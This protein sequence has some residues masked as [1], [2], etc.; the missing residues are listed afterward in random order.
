[1]LKHE[2]EFSY[3]PRYSCLTLSPANVWKNDLDKFLGDRMIIKTI[4]D[5]KDTSSLESGSLKELLFGLPW[6]QTGIRKL[7]VRN[8]Q[9]A[10]NYAITLVFK[11]FNEELIESLKRTLKQQFPGRPFKSD[12]PNRTSSDDPLSAPGNEHSP[13]TPT[14]HLYFEHQKHLSEFRTLAICYL[15]ALVIIYAI[16]RKVDLIKNKLLLAFSAVLTIGMSLLSSIGI[17]FWLDFNPTLN[18]S[19]ILPYL[20]L[21]VGEH[22]S[23][24]EQKHTLKTRNSWK[25]INEKFD[26]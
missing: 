11:E 17:C 19:D 3:L 7:Y 23:F 4:F 15:L 20:V 6:A 5:I 22:L 9:R 26:H 25:K 14:V 8:R 2:T 24:K 1:M 13:N 10:I 12:T 16:T 18:G 21:L